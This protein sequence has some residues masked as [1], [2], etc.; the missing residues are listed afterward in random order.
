MISLARRRSSRC[1]RSTLPGSL[2]SVRALVSQ[3]WMPSTLLQSALRPASEPRPGP[4]HQ[5]QGKDA[6]CRSR[7][8]SASDGSS[9]SS[10]SR[11]S[12]VAIARVTDLGQPSPRPPSLPRTLSWTPATKPRLLG[13]APPRPHPPESPRPKQQQPSG[14]HLLELQR[15]RRRREEQAEEAGLPVPP[16]ATGK[17]GRGKLVFPQT[18][19]YRFVL[20]I[21][22]LTQDRNL[23]GVLSALSIAERKEGGVDVHGYNACISGMAKARRWADALALLQRMRAAGV[24]PNTACYSNAI[25]ACCRCG[26]YRHAPLLRR[27]MTLTNI[28][29]TLTCYRLELEHFGNGGRWGAALRL[30]SELKEAGLTP[31]AKVYNG[32]LDAFARSK[33]WARAGIVLREMAR[34]GHEL[35]ARSYRGLIVSAANAGEWRVAWRAFGEMT[36]RRVERSSRSTVIFNAVAAVCGASGRWK[37]ALRAVRLTVGGGMTPSL[38]AYNATL[39]AL[40]KAGQWQHARRLLEDMQRASPSMSPRGGGGYVGWGGNDTGRFG[41]GGRRT[42]GAVA[43]PHPSPDVYSYTSV[44]DACAKSS[45]GDGR[46]LERALEVFEDMRRANVKPS[47]VTFNTLI[48]ACGGGGRGS[49]NPGRGDWR[50]ALSFVQEMVESGIEPNAYTL[51]VAVAACD[52][53]GE[54]EEAALVL[55]Q[56]GAGVAAA[57]GGN[58]GAPQAEKGGGRGGRAVDEVLAQLRIVACGKAN[59]WKAGFEVVKQLERSAA[60]APAGVAVYNAL[61]EALVV[62]PQQP[63]R[64][65]RQR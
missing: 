61:I 33:E 12:P 8:T 30:L 21:R 47:L 37:E 64:N 4:S 45:D 3:S 22:E 41:A 63:Q 9:S 15:Q 49:G 26:E 50:R 53:G 60:G 20:H 31:D 11:S 23:A 28:P 27:E 65:R 40:G 14:D 2:S 13:R 58:G 16:P 51:T 43:G 6:A 55:K 46:Q 7:C 39:G 36:S 52:A 34:A 57:G 18:D 42:G 38:I 48:L 54:W 35:H 5:A 56:M 29:Q 10:S 19:S 17:G 1:R 62:R 25:L 32:V 59:D 44:I 24:A